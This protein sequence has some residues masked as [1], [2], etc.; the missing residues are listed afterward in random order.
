MKW[1]RCFKTSFYKAWYDETEDEIYEFAD[2]GANGQRVLPVGI[3]YDFLAAPGKKIKTITCPKPYK[4][5][6][7]EDED[8]GW[9]KKD[10]VEP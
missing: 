6:A 9:W 5:W 8:G 10:T 1:L 3:N 4:T 7:K 2:K